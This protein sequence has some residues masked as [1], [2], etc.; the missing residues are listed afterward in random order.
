VSEPERGAT[1][2]VSL[3]VRPEDCASALQLT[4]DPCDQYPEVFATTRMIAL[5]EYAG[6]HLLHEHVS[7]GE[8]SV[9]ATASFLF[10]MSSLPIP[11]AR[12]DAAR[13]NGP[14]SSASG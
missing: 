14:S 12:S 2:S 6:A 3:I 10:S 7:E 13:T 4:D 8:M 1:A 11:P 9:G 5:M